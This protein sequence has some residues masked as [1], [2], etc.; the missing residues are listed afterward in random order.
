MSYSIGAVT[1]P[2]A[3][4]RASKRN[5]AKV[6][7]FEIDGDLPILIIPGYSAEE[8]TLEGF[9]VGTKS[10]IETNYLSPLEALKGT[11]V[12]VAF[13]DSRY[14]G[15]W[16]LADF[17]YTELDAKRFTYKIKLLK[18]SSHIVL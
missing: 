3:P 4:S 5:P 1:L 15:D 6:E 18:G 13:P 7:T 8:L 11:E 14:D 9:L 17:T 16:I 2:T 10:T 12:T